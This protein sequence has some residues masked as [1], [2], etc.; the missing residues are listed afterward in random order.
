MLLSCCFREARNKKNKKRKSILGGKEEEKQVVSRGEGDQLLVDGSDQPQGVE[1]YTV[2][3]SAGRRGQE[4]HPASR[5]LFKQRSQESVKRGSIPWIDQSPVGETPN[6]PGDP[7]SFRHCEDESR[8]LSSSSGLSSSSPQKASHGKPQTLISSTSAQGQAQTSLIASSDQRRAQFS[9]GG[10]RYSPDPVQLSQSSVSAQNGFDKA[11]A[12]GTTL[13][14]ALLKSQSRQPTNAKGAGAAVGRVGGSL[15]GQAHHLPP[16]HAS[17]QSSAAELKDCRSSRPPPL[18]SPSPSLSSSSV[19]SSEEEAR[20]IV[21]GLKKSTAF[22]DASLLQAQLAEDEEG[23]R[24][25]QE[26]AEARRMVE[27][28]REDMRR[29]V[30]VERRRSEDE[31]EAAREKAIKEGE[32]RMRRVLE[33]E[34]KARMAKFE[35]QQRAEREEAERKFAQRI[36]AEKELHSKALET[37]MMDAK[38]EANRTISELNREVV[39]ERGKLVA[40]QQARSRE[41]EEEWRVKE[42]RLQKSLLEVEGREQEWQEERAEVLAEVQRLKAEASR[43]VAILAMEAEEEN[44]SEEKKLSLGQEVY[45][46]QLVVDMRTGEVRS[47]RQQLAVANQQLECMDSLRGQLEKANARLDDLQAQVLNKNAIEKQ[48]SQEKSQLELSVDSSNKAVERMSQNVEELQWRIRNNFDLP[49]QVAGGEGE[50]GGNQQSKSPATSPLSP[51]SP[52]QH[53]SGMRNRPQSTPLPERRLDGSPKKASMFSVSQAMIEA[54]TIVEDSHTTSDFSPSSS[55]GATHSLKIDEPK[56]NYADSLGSE[57]NG[58]DDMEEQQSDSEEAETDSLDEGL[59]DISSDQDSPESPGPVEVTASETLTVSRV[60]R[61]EVVTPER[62]MVLDLQLSPS[63]H[64]DPAEERR[65]VLDLQLAPNSQPG[66]PMKSPTS[67]ERM[68]SRIT[69]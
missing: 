54:T 21:R 38:N 26:G 40:E 19:Q 45:S 42:E 67:E 53:M 15:M 24:R 33:E 55:D 69:M 2:S 8:R 7:A 34:F 66:S 25:E 23:R 5:R 18:S 49:V 60:E 10:S 22:H 1:V 36:A 39:A 37:A 65:M 3:Q 61:A 57:C 27:M 31:K 12:Q 48:L 47:L 68:P 30:E 14:A 28:E 6:L 50:I 46:L 13:S 51:L 58:R 43:M 32:A 62:R 9:S 59:G 41:L 35:E 44:L 56:H 64:S 63:K 11:P 29:R 20:P 17:N 52:G 4:R 16:N